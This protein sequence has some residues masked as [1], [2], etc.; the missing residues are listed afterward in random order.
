M[1]DE[2]IDLV[3]RLPAH[4]AMLTNLRSACTRLTARPE[5]PFWDQEW[6]DYCPYCSEHGLMPMHFQF[7]RHRIKGRLRWWYVQL[8]RCY[9]FARAQQW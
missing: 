3:K 1:S 7:C 5:R 8:W 2:P 9:Q 4:A 6:E